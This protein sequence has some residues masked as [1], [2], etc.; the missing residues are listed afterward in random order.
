MT[1]G[2]E[3]G[4][5][6]HLSEKREIKLTYAGIAYTTTVSSFIQELLGLQIEFHRFGRF[7]FLDSGV[8][9]F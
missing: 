1:E 4:A 3:L 7:G 2:E 6:K 9:D 8:S 5:S